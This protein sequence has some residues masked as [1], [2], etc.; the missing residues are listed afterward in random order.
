MDSEN[1]N[2]RL[3]GEL[4]EH[5]RAQVGDAG[6]YANASE[7]VRDLIRQDKKNREAGWAW[8]RE[9]LREGMLADDSAFVEESA[10]EAIAKNKK[11]LGL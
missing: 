7:Y 6:L 1:L 2:V 9:E 10:A 8:L 3:T 4:R 11:R 5:L